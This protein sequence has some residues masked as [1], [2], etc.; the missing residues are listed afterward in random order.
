MTLSTAW[1][2]LAYRVHDQRDYLSDYGLLRW[3]P[4]LLAI[5][6]ATSTILSIGPWPVG[7]FQD[8]GIYVVLAKALANGDGYRYTNIPGAPH[9]THYPPLY[10][11]F[12]A[13][14]WKLYPSFPE[15]VTLFKFVNAAFVGITAALFY[16]FAQRVVGLTKWPAAITVVAFTACRPVLYLATMVLSEPLFMVLLGLSLILAERAASSGKVRDALGATIVIVALSLTRTL[17]A[18]LLPALVLALLYRR[19]WR[20]AFVVTVVG[21]CGLLPWQLWIAAHDAEIPSIFIGKYG[22]YGRW[23]LDAFRVEGLPFV[24]DVVAK[25]VRALFMLGSTAAGTAFSW[26]PWARVLMG[27]VT[28]VIFGIGCR[29]LLKRALV[30]FIFLFAYIG[31]VIVWPFSPDRFVWAIWPLLGAVAV[32]GITTTWAASLDVLGSGRAHAVGRIAVRAAVV[33]LVTG[34][35]LYNSRMF[36]SAERDLNV[37]KVVGERLRPVAEWVAAHTR[38]QDVL[39]TDSDALVYLYTGR[40]AIPNGVFTPQEYIHGQSVSFAIEQLQTIMA[41]YDP[42]Y[43]LATSDY[44]VYAVRGSLGGSEKGKLYLVDVLPVGAAFAVVR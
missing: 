26:S 16:V 19:H 40:R 37:Q 31:V 7:V 11:A 3:M 6:A 2:T 43:V 14:L 27:V 17:G 22:S 39:A 34:H 18:V 10:P 28:L 25:N 42:D 44:A 36:L 5:I 15:N 9:A 12:L 20:G 4:P 13:L 41:V 8:D 38:Q 35:V 21:V 1:R 30:T 33:V 32:L 24:W 29:H 23:L